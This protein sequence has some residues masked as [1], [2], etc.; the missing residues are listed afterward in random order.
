[1]LIRAMTLL[2]LLAAATPDAE[3]QSVHFRELRRFDAAEATQAVAVDADCFYAIANSVIGKYDRESG[4]RLRQ[5]AASEDLPLRHLNSGIVLGERLYCA[6][7]NFPQFPEASSIEVWDTASLEHV[8]SHSLGIC[9]GSLTW[10]ELRD[11]HWWAVFAHYSE[12]V[13]DNPFAKSHRWT[14]LVRF[15]RQWRREAGWIFPDS[16]LD[17]FAP[18]SCSGGGW[19]PDGAL[20]CTGHDRGEVYRLTLPRAGSTLQLT[21]TAP[22]TITGQGIAWDREQNLLFGI[23][24]PQRQVVVSQWSAD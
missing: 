15:D 22:A 18:H 6:H 8:E 17:R 14:S 19:G 13:N 5:W 11:G 9:E 24:R 10:I 2:L 16:V 4:T 3:A 23:D 7:S 12:H 1:M 21:H 20:Y